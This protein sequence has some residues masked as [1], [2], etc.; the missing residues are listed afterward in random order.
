[1]FMAC[2][3]AGHGTGVVDVI[4][5][6][7]KTV[8]DQISKQENWKSDM[9]WINSDELQGVSKCGQTTSWVFIMYSQLEPELRSKWRI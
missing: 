6:T 8:Y 2:K 4:Y 1:M 3:S 9:Q 7:W 5:Q